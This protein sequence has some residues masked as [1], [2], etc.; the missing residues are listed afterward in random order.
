MSILMMMMMMMMM[1]IKMMNYFANKRTGVTVEIRKQ[2][3]K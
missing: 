2:A 1:M 3:T